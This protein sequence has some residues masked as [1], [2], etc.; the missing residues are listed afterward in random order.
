MARKWNVSFDRKPE[1]DIEVAKLDVKLTARFSR[2]SMV[3]QQ[4]RR[5]KHIAGDV[6]LGTSRFRLGG[7]RKK[8]V[9][10]GPWRVL[11]N[12]KGHKKGMVC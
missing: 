9:N 2:G 4:R 12:K 5:T 6:F 11:L 7:E 10:A 1:R 3:D 8:W